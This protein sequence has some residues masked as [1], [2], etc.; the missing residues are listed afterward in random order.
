MIIGWQ[1]VI[2]FLKALSVEVKWT[3]IQVGSVHFS[4]SFIVFKHYIID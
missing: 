4:I 1:V 2:E 3:V